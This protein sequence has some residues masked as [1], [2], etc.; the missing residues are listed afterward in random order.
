MNIG[1]NAL[2]PPVLS[3]AAANGAAPALSG[4]YDFMSARNTKKAFSIVNLSNPS[5]LPPY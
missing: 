1:T 5:Q 3:F 4:F 2:L